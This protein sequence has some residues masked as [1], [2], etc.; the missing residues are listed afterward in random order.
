MDKETVNH[1]IPTED[2]QDQQQAEG[3]I[4]NEKLWMQVGEEMEQWPCP[5]PS[6]R[7]PTACGGAS[8]PPAKPHEET[9]H[10]SI[11]REKRHKSC[12]CKAFR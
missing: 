5:H 9:R 11:A 6:P 1:T 7:V 2:G 8:L 12:M 3:C 4:C 10:S